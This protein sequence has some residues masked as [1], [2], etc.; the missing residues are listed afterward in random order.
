MTALMTAPYRPILLDRRVLAVHAEP[1]TYKP[2]SCQGGGSKP[3][4]KDR[5]SL[6]VEAQQDAGKGPTGKPLTR[7]LGSAVYDYE[8]NQ[9]AFRPYRPR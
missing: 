4:T 2:R 5:S 3:L 9:V 6:S 7:R 8:T 1:S